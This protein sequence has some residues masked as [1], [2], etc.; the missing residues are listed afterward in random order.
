[1]GIALAVAARG[2]CRR[3]QIGAV[4]VDEQHRIVATGYNGAPP[5]EGSCLAGDCPRGR[6]TREQLPSFED[7]NQ[8]HSNCISLHAEQNAIAWADRSRC[9]GATIYLAQLDGVPVPPCDMCSK[10]IRAAGITR[11]VYEKE[12]L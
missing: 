11:V 12:S 6:Y 2:D 1:M 10:L 9:Q 5:G 4:I 7:G 3:R 8:D